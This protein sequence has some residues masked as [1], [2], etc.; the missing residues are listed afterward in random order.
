[1][2]LLFRSGARHRILFNDDDTLL[3]LVA[4]FPDKKIMA[5]LLDSDFGNVDLEARN[6]DNLTARELI[7]IR[8]SDPDIAL[9]FQKLMREISK[10]GTK[11]E[12]L[13]R[14]DDQDVSDSDSDTETFEDAFE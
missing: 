6:K 1:M 8:S 11:V 12:K 13:S 14:S 5:F 7:K 10:K 2:K 3:H 4:K 9:A